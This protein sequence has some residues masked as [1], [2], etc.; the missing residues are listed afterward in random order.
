M[1][2]PNPHS[3]GGLAGPA[4]RGTPLRTRYSCAMEPLRIGLSA[5]LLYPDPRRYFLPTKTVQYLEQSV[6][7]WV[8]SGE[9][10]AFM[11]PEMSLASPHLPANVAVRITW[12]RS[13][14]SCCRAAT[15]SLPRPMESRRSTPHGA[16]IP[17]AIATR[18]SS[19]RSSYARQAGVRHLPGLPAHQC[20]L[21]RHA[22]PGHRHAATWHAPAPRRR[23]YDRPCT[24]A[25][26]RG[27]L[28]REHVPQ[29]LRRAHQ[30]DPPPGGQ[31]P[32]Q[33][34]VVEAR[35]SP[36]ASSRPCAGRAKAS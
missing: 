34:L 12:T 27:D 22:V 14:A 17:S 19:W 30:L 26:P 35:A 18:S 31:G 33:E 11:I 7:N 24:I 9:V 8:M 3:A 28:A 36:T 20:G 23:A 32:R 1:A 21:R 6:A 15:T 29:R 25:H 10:L 4:H 16:A 2:T 5:R 13:T